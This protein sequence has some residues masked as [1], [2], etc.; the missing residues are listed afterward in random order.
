MTLYRIAAVAVVLLLG[1]QL[2][3]NLGESTKDAP[4]TLVLTQLAF[5]PA[6]HDLAAGLANHPPNAS[7]ATLMSQ[8]YP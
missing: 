4:P 2:L 1:V 7:F 8:A 3:A 6:R 5:L